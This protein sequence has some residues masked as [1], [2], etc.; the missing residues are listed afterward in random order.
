[1]KA[2]PNGIITNEKGLI[3][4]GQTGMDLRD[5]F[6][7]KSLQALVSRGDYNQDTCAV[8]AYQYADA[9]MRARENDPVQ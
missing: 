3:V 1:M 8:I 7:A 5:Y 9:M 4:G 6:A 2:F